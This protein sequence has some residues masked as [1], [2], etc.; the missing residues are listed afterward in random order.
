MRRGR[1]LLANRILMTFLISQ[2]PAPTLWQ[3]TSITGSN[4]CCPVLLS[5]AAKRDQTKPAGDASQDGPNQILALAQAWT[6]F[7]G[8]SVTSRKFPRALTIQASQRNSAGH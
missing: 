4:R 6:D 1:C 8:S 5:T 3:S 2:R 7:D